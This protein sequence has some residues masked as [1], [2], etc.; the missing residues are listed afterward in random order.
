MRS[1]LLTTLDVRPS[2]IRSSNEFLVKAIK[3]KSVLNVGAA[4]GIQS[5]LPDDI[6]IWPHKAFMSA[7]AEID[8]ID[9]NH[10]DIKYAAKYGYE[11]EYG[12]CEIVDRGKKYDAIILSDVIEH[13]EQPGRALVNLVGHLRPNGKLYITTPNPFY[14]ADVLRAL[15][16]LAPH[17]FWDHQTAYF[18]EHIQGICDRHNLRLESV[19]Y[20]T[21]TDSRA[22]FSV[23][24]AIIRSIGTLVPRLNQSFLA[25]ISAR[26]R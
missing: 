8:A 16:N 4:G 17:V 11:I 21:G 15:L 24:S 14:V 13:V 22:G 20:F 6:D 26:S 7:A 25:T 2:L 5:Y 19:A 9:I 23:K 18:A 12:N 3:G 1:G 10:E